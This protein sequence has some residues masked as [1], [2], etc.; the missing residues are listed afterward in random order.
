MPTPSTFY[1]DSTVFCDATDIWTDSSLSIP[2][3]D[4]WYQVGGVYRQKLSG[5]L[6]PCQACP[7]CGA[8][9]ADCDGPVNANAGQGVYHVNY[10]VGSAVGAVVIAFDPQNFP[11]ML[12]WSYNG[13]SASEYSSRPH[14][15]RQGYIG[16]ISTGG[17]L[18]PPIVNGSP[19]GPFVTAISYL[20]NDSLG[21][22]IANGT[23]SIPTVPA[24][25]VSLTTTGYN[26]L[27]R[28]YMVIPKTDPSVQTVAI[29][30]YGPGNSTVWNMVAYC[31]KSLNPFPYNRV[32]GSACS[33]LSKVMYTCSVAPGGDGTNTMLGIND[34]AFENYT[35]ETPVS[36]GVYPVE[37]GDGVTKCV[38]VDANGT[39]TNISA[40]CAGTC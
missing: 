29:T 40:A 22:F 12:T 9:F 8:G 5:V 2:S 37:D 21:V 31:P 10:D 34:W 39:I 14:G 33:P 24:T 4:G 17:L 28:A 35:G 13:L 23:E 27:D 18:T 36:A 30:I 7:E 38:T 11:D 25:D 16:S 6:G 19:A 26:V 20:W 15:Y 3:A 32:S 1:Y